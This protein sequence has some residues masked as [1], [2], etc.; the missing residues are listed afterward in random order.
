MPLDDRERQILADIE[1][2]LR[3]EDPRF[4]RVV[5][6]A[7]ATFKAR[8]QI[9]LAAIGFVVGLLMMLG[10]VASLWWGLAGFALML[11]STVHA[12][13]M[14]KRLGEQDAAPGLGGQLR[15]GLR[16]LLEGRRSHDAP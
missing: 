16:R 7:T 4:V 8:H 2:R 11:A 10:L 9:K 1:A 12:G 5:G 3:E 14:L 15:G 13:N 6:N